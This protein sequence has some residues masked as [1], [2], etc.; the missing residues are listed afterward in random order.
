MA[1][2]HYQLLFGIII[3]FDERNF[4]RGRPINLLRKGEELNP[5]AE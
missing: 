1:D 5:K 4:K 3:V 2:L